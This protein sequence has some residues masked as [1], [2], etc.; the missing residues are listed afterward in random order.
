MFAAASKTSNT[1]YV[2][3]PFTIT[4][5][6]CCNLGRKLKI[7]TLAVVAVDFAIFLSARVCGF[8]LLYDRFR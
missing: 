1:A 3:L 2:N 5:G 8:V 6:F 7:D 4:T